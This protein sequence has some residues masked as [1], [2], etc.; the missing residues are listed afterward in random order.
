V[1]FLGKPKSFEDD[2]EDIGAGDHRKYLYI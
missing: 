2:E 1:F